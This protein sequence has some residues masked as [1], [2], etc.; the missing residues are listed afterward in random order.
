MQLGWS[1]NVP[2]VIE[3]TGN[4]IYCPLTQI[5]VATAFNIIDP[6]DTHISELFIQISTGYIIN[7]D[8]LQLTGSHP[9]ISQ[10]WNI[11]QG[12]LTLSGKNGA[13][14]PY[15]DMINAVLQVVFESNSPTIS[16]DRL[17]SFSIGNANYLPAT[18]HYY[19][20]I[21]SVGIT[22]NDAKTAASNLNYYGLQ[23][24]LATIGSAEE[25]QLAGEQASGAGWIGGTDEEVEGVWKWATGPEAGTVFWNGGVNGSSPTGQYANW[26]TD[27]PN[28]LGNENYAHITAPGIGVRGSWND[29]SNTGSASGDYQPKGFIVE[30]GGMPGD[31]TIDISAST[32]ITVKKIESTT[33]ASR[34]GIGT[35]TLKATT[36]AEAV[37]LWYAAPTGGP[38]IASGNSFVT[39]SLSDTTTY[40]ALSSYNGCT[41]GKRTPVVATVMKTPTIVSISEETICNEGSGTLMA[42]PSMGQIDWYD[43]PIGGTLLEVGNNFVT[44]VLSSTTTYYAEANHLGCLS[45]TRTPLT[46][47]V[48]KTEAP[49]GTTSQKFC[50]NLNATV[51]D[52]VVSGNDITWYSSPSELNALSLSQS[53]ENGTYYASQTIASCEGERLAVKVTILETAIPPIFADIPM[54]QECDSDADGDAFNGFVNFDLTDYN[55]LLLNG[56]PA[57]NFSITYFTDVDHSNSISNPSNF[58]NTIQDGQTIYVQIF[59]NAD[60]TCFTET[61]FLISVEKLP[62]VKSVITYKNC[63]EDGVADGL[64]D[65]NLNEIDVLLNPMN[66]PDLKI[67]YHLTMAEADARENALNPSPFNNAT[68]STVYARVEN[69]NGCYVV[70][71]I[72][73]QVSTTSFPVNYLQVMTTCDND[74]NNDGFHAFDLTLTETEFIQQFPTGQDLSVHYYTDLTDAELNQNEIQNTSNYINDT[75]FSQLIYVRVQSEDNGDCFGVGP[76]LQLT[77][78]PLPEFSVDQ[79]EGFCLN[80]GPIVLET[81]NPSGNFTY[82]WTDQM[83]GV[84]STEPTATV[85]SGG[86]Y[87][88]VASSMFGC[89]SLPVEFDVIESG[90]ANLTDASVSIDDLSA[91]NTITIDTTNLGIGDYEF[92]LGSIY[93]P[94]QD[95]PVFTNVP[96]GIYMLYANDKNGCGIAELEIYVLG[97]PKYF[98]PNNDGYNDLWNIKGFDSQFSQHSYID[99]F[100]R[101]GTYLARIKPDELGWDGTHNGEPLL[102]S[103]YWFVAHFVNSIGQLRT[104]KGHF[105][106]KR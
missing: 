76:H 58:L 89:K 66:A 46:L 87:T 17:F 15:S 1:Q 32:Q 28:N 8:E 88:V 39:P 29:L 53:L 86:V 67:T 83:G 85:D 40:Y 71:T 54:M 99:I 22:W 24:Y 60:N 63:D 16:G 41:N 74:V 104:F 42:T 80:G 19:E 30:Y 44:P 72:N 103:D 11:T 56:K 101:Y 93:G 14:V 7:Q 25:S 96:A 38:A 81:Y 68:A 20:F 90:I 75:P 97:F 77:V 27:E 43:A 26:N 79:S 70:S 37:V 105:T 102:T 31:P 49:T 82:I 33:E 21:S 64:T 52:L 55:A 48:Q 65:F 51:A 69:S 12:K 5:P 62:L 78:N 45:T 98:T 6:D 35:L 92:S 3:A 50:E 95:E 2:P 4:Q 100:N 47:T 57:S 36:A 10:S 9:N 91:S 84:I 106:L 23:G 13:L 18:G 94:Y 34:C 73:L 59:N 61:S